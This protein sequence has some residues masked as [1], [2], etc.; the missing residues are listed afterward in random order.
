MTKILNSELAAVGC[1]EKNFEL[2]SPAKI[3]MWE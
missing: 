3:A 1:N 2:P